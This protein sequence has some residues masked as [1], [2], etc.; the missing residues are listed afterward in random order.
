MMRPLWRTTWIGFL[1]ST[2][3]GLVFA[4]QFYLYLH[5]FG[6]PVTWAQTLKW[7][8]GSWY[9]WAV[10]SPAILW[11]SRRVALTRDRWLRAVTTHLAF[12]VLVSAVHV[13][14]YA[15][16]TWLAA[17]MFD[18]PP[19][20]TGSVRDSF[21]RGFSWELFCY[22]AIAVAFHALDTARRE[23]QARIRASQ[24]ETQLAH[25]QLDALRMQLHPHFLFNTLN[26]IMALIRDDPQGAEEMVTRL[27]DLL[28]LTLE[29]SNVQEIP[30]RQE[31]DFARKYLDIQRVRFGERLE[32][33]F[34]VAPETLDAP[35]PTFMLQPVIENA[36]RHGLDSEA[37]TCD[38]RVV[39]RMSEG[40]L[41]I[42]VHDTGPGIGGGGDQAV[43]EGIG[44][45]NTKARLHQVYGDRARFELRNDSP[46]GCVVSIRIPIDGSKCREAGVDRG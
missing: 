7:N 39:S 25:A 43:R 41:L 30:L 40:G 32:S 37:G 17:P 12:G 36:V 45:S 29:T 15:T 4:A 46:I 1:C 9:L 33:R 14:T 22:A 19:N 31:L 3:I 34:E 42:E 23:R 2:L 20:W 35:V 13:L 28:R 18:G 21:T 10:L 27:S 26:T 38:I 11:T 44:I 6:R 24:L 5:S 16:W 8:L